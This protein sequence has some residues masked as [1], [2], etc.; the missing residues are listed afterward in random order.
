MKYHT[1]RLIIW[2]SLV[3]AKI[4]PRRIQAVTNFVAAFFM[5]LRFVSSAAAL[6]GASAAGL[7]IARLSDVVYDG[8][9]AVLIFFAKVKSL[10]RTFPMQFTRRWTKQA[11]Q[12]C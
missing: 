12:N 11:S 1:K 6:A 7:L 2:R 8:F 3:Q 10:S 5:Y 4:G 9:V